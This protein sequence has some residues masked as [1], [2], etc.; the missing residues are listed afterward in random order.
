MP[1][2]RAVPVSRAAAAMAETQGE[3][4]SKK[5]AKAAAEGALMAEASP[6]PKKRASVPATLSL[7]AR[8]VKAASATSQRVMPMG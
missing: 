2:A 7:A 6:S 1:R 8:P 3:Q 5:A 4:V